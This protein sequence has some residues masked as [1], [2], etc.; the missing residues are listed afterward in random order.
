MNAITHHASEAQLVRMVDRPTDRNR[1]MTTLEGHP[2][3]WMKG[4]SFILVG[5]L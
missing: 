2:N 4:L 3:E 5:I 1:Q